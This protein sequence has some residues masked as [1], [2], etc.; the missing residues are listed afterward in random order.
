[1]K[2]I[3]VAS[4]NPVKVT[5]ALSGFIK[6]FPSE[7][8]KAVAVQAQSDVSA[9]PFTSEETLAGALNR[10]AN[11]RK[12]FPD[13]DFW[14]GIEGGVEEHRQELAVF[15]WVV[16]QSRGQ[17][18][19]GRTG[20]FYLPTQISDLVRSGTELGEADD[21]IFHRSNS[22]QGNGAIGLLTGDVIDRSQLYEMAVVFA[23]LPFRNKD[24]YRTL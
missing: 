10:S 3:V 11:A 7:E 22:K 24:L 14:V 19:K 15:A 20:T 8:F 13:A 6:M 12:I 4:Q 2:T 17:I 21:I 18:G 23:L 5:A 9:Q 16:I 1:M